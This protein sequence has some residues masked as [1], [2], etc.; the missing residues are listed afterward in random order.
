MPIV[1]IENISDNSSVILWEVTETFEEL[2]NLGKEQ[3]IQPPETDIHN[4]IKKMEWT[5]GR[6]ALKA[7]I[8]SIGLEYEGII[9]DEHGKP[10]L[11][12]IA[13]EISLTH[14]FP[15]IG[16]IYNAEKTVGIDW[17][18]PKLKMLRIAH[19]FLSDKELEH[20]QEDINKICVYWCAKE[21]LY[22]L[23][24][25]KSII[26]KEQL[27]IEPFNLSDDFEVIGSIVVD[28]NIHRHK[29]IVKK[30]KGNYLVFTID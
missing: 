19:K 12:E 20:A 2:T 6:L 15:W 8:E 27:P 11:K 4:E 13:G 21:A 30:I 22:K 28:N 7:L 14:S 1:K 5:V 9:K 10:H 3:G 29:L 17:E 23:Y 26:F 25:K 16:A 18:Q 24:G